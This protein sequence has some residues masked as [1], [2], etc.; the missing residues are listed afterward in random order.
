MCSPG[1]EYLPF[2]AEAG[3][4]PGVIE[5]CKAVRNVALRI[6][7]DISHTGV[8]VDLDRVAA[9]AI[10]HDIGRSR[11]HGMGHADEG[12]DICRSKGFDEGICRIVERHIGAGLS[13]D[14]RAGF[15]LSAVDRIPKTLEEKIV[16]HADNLVKGTR[17][18]S[19]EEFAASLER[20]DEPVR[21]RFLALA[22][23][24]ER[25]SRAHSD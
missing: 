2:L 8:Q 15:G 14:E 5:H 9:G 19:R 4:D 24:L 1:D 13:A 25:L 18:I 3:C 6:A 20:F 16:A 11:T 17:V 7:S 21:S 10:L 12:G 23:E 22:D